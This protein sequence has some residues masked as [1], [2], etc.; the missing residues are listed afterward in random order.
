ML[1]KNQI[2]LRYESEAPQDQG[3][4]KKESLEDARVGQRIP[5][6]GL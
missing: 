5:R 6:G 3:E 4:S 1:F 2:R